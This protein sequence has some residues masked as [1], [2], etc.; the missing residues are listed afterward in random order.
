MPL[1]IVVLTAAIIS[2]NRPAENGECHKL[3]ADYGAAVDEAVG[4]IGDI[5][6]GVDVS[7]RRQ[8]EVSEK[9]QGL[10]EKADKLGLKGVGG[11]ECWDE[12]AAYQLKWAT[13][14]IE[15]QRR[16]IQEF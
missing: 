11:Q 4:M 6:E 14:A 1:V 13:A 5:L 7:D 10:S 8:Q 12:F 2:C 16:A 9:L 3:V 15:L